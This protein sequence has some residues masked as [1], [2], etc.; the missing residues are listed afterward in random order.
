MDGRRSL[1][2]NGRGEQNPAY[3]LAHPLNRP[4]ASWRRGFWPVFPGNREAS[5]GAVNRGSNLLRWDVLP[6]VCPGGQPLIELHVPPPPLALCRPAH[7]SCGHPAGE[8]LERV[9]G[10]LD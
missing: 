2:G 1:S 9:I 5:L 10:P 8:V 7:V 4:E 6:I 3:R